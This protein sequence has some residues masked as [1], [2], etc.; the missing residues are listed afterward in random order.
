MAPVPPTMKAVSF[1]RPGDVS[2]LDL[3]TVPV[4]AI[5]PDEVLIRNTYA[6]VNFIDTYFRSGQY[7]IANLPMILGQEAAGT[8]VQVGAE[9]DPK[10]EV[11]TQVVYMPAAGAGTY[12]EYTKVHASRVI[13]IPD[14][15]DMDKAVAVYLQ[16]LTAWTF[17]KR[18]AAVQEGEWTLVHAAAGG[19]GS[20]LVQLLKIVGAK[21]IATAS[22][23]EKLKIATELGADYTVNSND[24]VVKRVDEITG[25]HGV[26]SIFD[27]VGKATFEVDLKMIAL[28]GNLVMLGNSVSLPSSYFFSSSAYILGSSPVRYELTHR[29]PATS[30]PLTF[31]PP[32]VPRTSASRAP[33]SLATRPTAPRWKSTRR[34]CLALWP[35]A[36]LKCCST[37]CTTWRMRRRRIRTLL[38]A[39]RLA[40]CSSRSTD[41]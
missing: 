39:R 18:A 5:G 11:G 17:I 24:D 25:G 36:R 37:A 30:S 32:S 13:R 31:V 15:V 33:S 41:G 16:G 8:V 20:L 19:V 2:V 35:A 3:T 6:G 10:F 14:G 38:A 1:A 12:C 9:A 7:P 26:D 29:S 40:S 34:S 23:E 28:G 21:V 27:G 22:S 4:P